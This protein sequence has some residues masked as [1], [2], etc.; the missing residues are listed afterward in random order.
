MTA[1]VD[2]MMYAGDVPWHG[3]GTYV[4]DSPVLSGEAITA[5]GLDWQVEKWPLMAFSMD[6][7][8]TLIVPD[9]HQTIRVPGNLPLGTVGSGYEIVQNDEAFAFLDAIVGPGK[10]LRYH[11]AGALGHGHR[12]WMLAEVV[13]LIIEP[14]PGD[15][16]KVYLLLTTGHDGKWVVSILWTSV[17]VVCQNTL[18]LALGKGGARVKIRHTSKVTDRLDH[19]RDIL[20]L[21][22]SKVELY[23][24]LATDLARI[25]MNK[26]SLD[27]FLLK[28]VKDP[29]KGTS[30][31]RAQNR[32]KE[33]EGLFE[34][35]PG[36]DLKGVG[37]TA[38]AA[39]QAVTYYTTH[40]RSVRGS[41]AA[42]GA[43]KRLESSW[44]GESD[45]LNQ[46]ALKI[47]VPG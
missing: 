40:A 43:E 34:T 42:G 17:R 23:Q 35:S 22:T 26:K 6:T 12:V 47:L 10:L 31:T 14:V 36:N 15:V 38:W 8:D 18:N 5:A 45:N 39:L 19:A 1:N 9:M 44:F 2:S 7:D 37:G 4:G 41:T 3:L 16:T 24:E 28:L 11:T 46:K 13:D 30:P 29:P 32:R 33:I 20:G 25:Q 27:D 21:T